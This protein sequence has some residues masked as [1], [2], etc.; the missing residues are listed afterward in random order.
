MK[1]D[2]YSEKKSR[3]DKKL[4]WSR[5]TAQL[6]FFILFT[7]TLWRTAY[8]RVFFSFDPLLSL[9]VCIAG[10]VFLKIL[11]PSALILILTALLGRFFCGWICPLG[12]M[13]DITGALRKKYLKAGKKDFSPQKLKYIKF[14]VFS[15]MLFFA[16]LGIQIVWWGDPVTIAG[17]FISMNLIPFTIN[18]VE[19][20]FKI[21]LTITGHPE[22]LTG[23]Y[24]S[25]RQGIGGVRLE[26][27]ASSFG[28]LSL[29]LSIMLLTLL[30]RRFWC[31]NICPLGALLALISRVS[32][33]KREVKKEEC[34]NCNICV[35]DCRMGAI[36]SDNSYNKQEC[37]LC[38]DCLY[39]CPKK[40]TAFK[41]LKKEKNKSINGS[42]R[43]FLKFMA[44]ALV[45]GA[46]KGKITVGRTS[47]IIRPPGA[48]KEKNFINR[49][50][51]CGNCMRVCVTNG[52][53][54]V[55]TEAGIGGIWTPKLVPEIGNCEYLCNLCGRECPTGAIPPLAV[56]VKKKTRLGT[57]K[58]NRNRCLPWKH[59]QQCIVCEEHCPVSQK[60]IKVIEEKV[61][62][63]LFQKPV[64]DIDLCI[65]CGACQNVCPVR[66][67]RAIMVNPDTASRL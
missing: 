15:V 13:I 10:R 43:D 23:L 60:A 20:F 34:T 51:R 62:G 46:Q 53:Q 38:M 37:V 6:F 14:I 4:G 48:L 31:R 3:P 52:L 12:S 2:Q 42:R 35:S 25:I 9:G 50:I 49:C 21:L 65:G 32:P 66:P 28:I 29:W 8:T 58:V 56:E 30:S 41:F 64:V 18:S 67:L 33:L 59:E 19:S 1:K 45:A 40:I 11:I 54:P 47:G 22:S 61:N 24:R 39:N 26:Y 27:F 44:V 16:L 17:R 5:K 55:T 57:A 36:N 7:V 63:R